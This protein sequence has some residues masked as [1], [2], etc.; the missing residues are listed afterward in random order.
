MKKIVFVSLALMACAGPAMADKAAYCQAYARDFSDQVATD[1]IMW[2][3]KFQ[4]AIDACLGQG[5]QVTKG[6]APKKQVVSTPVSK[7]DQPVL[8][9]TAPEPEKLAVAKPAPKLEKV[10][11]AKSAPKLEKVAVAK[12]ASKPEKVVVAKP[13]SAALVAGT[14]QWNTY[15]AQKYT[16][17]NPKTGMY[18]S[19]TGVARKCV[20]PSGFKA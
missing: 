12:P 17:F 16:S 15:C 20:V 3:H 13:P 7:P 1:K 8:T 18:L 5:K 9:D 14:P 4:I 10:A 19:K 2:Q 11:V 6:P